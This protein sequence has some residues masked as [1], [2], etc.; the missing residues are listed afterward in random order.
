MQY[1]ITRATDSD[2]PLMQRLFYQTVTTYGALLFTKD[3]IKI[4]SRLAT[5]KIY[6]Q[7]KFKK[8]FIYN[9]KLNG[10]IVGSF[11]MDV[12]GN[13]EYFFVHMNY[14]GKGIA[15]Q[16]YIT[17]EE[18]A[19]KEGIKTLTIQIHLATKVFFEKN[20]FDIVKNAVKVVGGNEIINYSG[21]KK[22]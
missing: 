12:N 1:Q 7:K 10:E 14:H 4:Y 19:K 5:N 9:A 15:R 11:S 13:I 16:L 18:V 20:G 2:L 21:V 17:L 3:E 6:W 22:L 8:G